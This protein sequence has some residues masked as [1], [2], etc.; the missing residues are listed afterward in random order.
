MFW[1]RRGDVESVVGRI[2]Q[3]ITREMMR[4][5]RVWE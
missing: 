5:L 1:A 3:R 4:G 2:I